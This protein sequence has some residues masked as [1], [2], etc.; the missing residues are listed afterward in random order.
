MVSKARGIDT[1]KSFTS[2]LA[3]VRYGKNEGNYP[4][5]F[6][7]NFSLNFEKIANQFSKFDLHNFLKMILVNERI[8]VSIQ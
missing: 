6:K 7:E 8:L 2:L 5:N 1:R 4:H 3:I